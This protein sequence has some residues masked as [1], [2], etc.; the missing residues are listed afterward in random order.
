MIDLFRIFNGKRVL[1]T[2][3]TGFKGSWLAYICKFLGSSVYGLSIDR[4]S[5]FRHSFHSLNISALLENS[6]HQIL[7]VRTDEFEKYILKIQPDFVFHLAAQAIVSKSYKDPMA[8]F[9]S[10]ILGILN[11]LETVRAH[12]LSSTLI[13]VTSDKC[14][15]NYNQIKPYVETDELG[16]NDPYSASKAAAEIVVGSYLAS[17]PTFAPNGVASVRA[18]NVFGGGDWSD[19]RLL[20]DCIRS[21]ESNAPLLIR[22]P[23]ATRPWTYVLDILQGYLMLAANLRLNP[24]V[25]RGAWN[26]ASGENKTVRQIAEL[27]S[28][29]SVMNYKIEESLNFQEEKLLQIDATKAKSTLG[30]KTQSSIEDSLIETLEWYSIQRLKPYSL[31]T[32]TDEILSKRFHA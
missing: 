26:F 12:K 1:I 22:N 15:K 21:I 5:D 25:Y 16:G 2:G 31:H 23:Q 30:W 6:Q 8:T 29:N 24:L 27:I 32:Y 18:G 7:D 17:F 14:Y 4:P 20:P 28:S 9:T 3:H 11:L 10:N 19:N 13:V